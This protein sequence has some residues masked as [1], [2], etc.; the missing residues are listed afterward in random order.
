MT[1]PITERHHFY[2]EQIKDPCAIPLNVKSRTSSGHF[3]IADSHS[4]V[5]TGLNARMG[6]QWILIMKK[7][8]NE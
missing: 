3:T 1:C 8:T 5:S 4:K 7:Q 6:A 2:A